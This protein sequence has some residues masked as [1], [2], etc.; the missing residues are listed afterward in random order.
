MKRFIEGLD[1]SQSTLFPERLEDWV[2]EDNPVRVVDVDVRQKASPYRARFALCSAILCSSHL[3][4]K[5]P[6]HQHSANQYKCAFP[7]RLPAWRHF[8]KSSLLSS[9]YFPDW[10]EVFPVISP[11]KCSIS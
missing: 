3:K 2:C 4:M 5:G 7:E 9:L 11:G 1:R 8:G 10:V 6:K